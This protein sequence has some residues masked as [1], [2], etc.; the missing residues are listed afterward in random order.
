MT[1]ADLLFSLA[2]GTALAGWA[3]LL[4]L[5]RWRWSARL[6]AGLL[7]P[8]IL[9]ALYL[10]LAAAHFGES[11]AGFGSLAQVARFFESPYSLLAGRVHYLAF[12]LFIGSWEV[13]DAQ[14]LGIPHLALVPCLVLTLFLGPIGLLAY[15]LLR[16]LWRRAWTLEV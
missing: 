15:F 8:G 7:V 5:P 11:E 14:R 16:A 10:W 12:D 13:R 4:F 2:T 1:T 3:L 9:S 6:V